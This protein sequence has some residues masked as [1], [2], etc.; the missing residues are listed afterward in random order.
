MDKILLRAEPAVKEL[1]PGFLEN[2]R[3]D[4]ERMRQALHAG[5]LAA[6]RDL[7]QNIR[8]FSRVYGLDELTELG[9]EIRIAAEAR[10]TLRIVLLH[11]RLADYLARVELQD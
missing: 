2:R 9:E 3:R 11:R 4:L 7:G 8:C 1:L 10:S 5:D 6:I